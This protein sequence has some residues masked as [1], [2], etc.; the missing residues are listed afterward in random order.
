M[1]R[2]YF[3]LVLALL[4]LP[5]ATR[6]QTTAPTEAQHDRAMQLVQQCAS[7]DEM[8]H[9]VA[10]NCYGQ[11]MQAGIDAS[12]KQNWNEAITEETDAITLLVADHD[13]VLSGIGRGTPDSL[14]SQALP[15]LV[16]SSAYEETKQYDLAI[17]DASSAIAIMPDN[18]EAWNDRCWTRAVSGDL[19]NALPDCQKSLQLAPHDAGVLDSTGFV[20]LKLKNYPAAVT[21][22]QSALAQNPK[23]ATS[24]YGK[25][26]AEQAA[27]NEAQA[28]QDI[29]AAQRLDANIAT[30]FGT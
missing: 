30:E 19:Q 7:V 26:L 2:I 8:D 27:G 5:A 14:A 12:K 18:A 29:E 6:A 10:T 21:S 20:Y 4:C 11:H 1:K 9:Y 13:R 23:L 17:S 15:Y 3:P 22:Y 28:T 25:G 24:L 16:R